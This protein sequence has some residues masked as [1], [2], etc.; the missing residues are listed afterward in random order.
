MDPKRLDAHNAAM[1]HMAKATELMK[2][3]IALHEAQ[4]AGLISEGDAVDRF[5]ELSDRAADETDIAAEAIRE[6]LGPES[7]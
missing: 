4:R 6:F 2:D 5:V 7:K 1:K 3:G